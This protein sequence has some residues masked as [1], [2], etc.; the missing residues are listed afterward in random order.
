MS[1][2]L[3]GIRVFDLTLILAGPR[4]TQMLGDLGAASSVAP[5]RHQRNR[6]EPIK[7]PVT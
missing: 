4:C 7:Q 5:S 3:D 2:P 1:G 6:G